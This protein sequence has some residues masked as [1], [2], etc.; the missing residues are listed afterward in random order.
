MLVIVAS[1]DIS[2]N[3]LAQNV[4]VTYFQNSFLGAK[5]IK[6]NDQELVLSNSTSCLQHQAGKGHNNNNDIKYNTTYKSPRDKTNKMACGR[7]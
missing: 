5:I 3:F 1:L 6:G 2:I 7:R 4:K